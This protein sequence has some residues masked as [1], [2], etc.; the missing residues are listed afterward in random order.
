MTTVGR[1]NKEKMGGWGGGVVVVGEQIIVSIQ[2]HSE[3]CKI[4]M[5]FTF[6]MSLYYNL[7]ARFI[8]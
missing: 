4:M 7:D 1:V 2:F 5:Y 8:L 6:Y 3:G